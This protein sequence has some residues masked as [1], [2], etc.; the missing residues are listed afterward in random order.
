MRIMCPFDRPRALTFELNSMG[1]DMKFEAMRAA[2]E[3]AYFKPKCNTTPSWH[4][5]MTVS[6]VHEAKAFGA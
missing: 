3:E 6:K 1:V 4:N 5:F 2:D